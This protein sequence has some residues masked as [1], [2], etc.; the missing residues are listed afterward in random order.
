MKNKS[1][2]MIFSELQKNKISPEEAKVLFAELKNQKEATSHSFQQPGCSVGE[3][4]VAIA[5]ETV[6]R[7]HSEGIAV[8]GMAGQFPDASDVNAFWKNLIQGHDAIHELP[9]NYLNPARNSNGKSQFY[10]WG[11][12]LAERDCFDPLFF[13]IAPRE[14]ESMNPHQRLIL[15]ESWKALEDAGYNPKKLADSQ[16]GIFIG[17]EPSGYVRELFT[18]FSDAIVA[19][20]LSY[21]LDLKGPAIVVNTGCSSSGAAIHL[22]CESLRSGESTLVIAGGVSANLCQ[23]DLVVLSEIGML[24]P[25]GRCRHLMNPVMAPFYPKESASW[26]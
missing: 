25:T 8:I 2:Q 13:N 21:Y 9:P 20:R 16:V 1:F 18:G 19:S 22:A 6:G 12:V 15:Q 5:G 10:P 26:Y 14:A 4:E 17:A 23:D 11:G 3:S 7:I 24:S